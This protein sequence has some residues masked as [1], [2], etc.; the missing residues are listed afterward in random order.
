MVFSSHQ[1]KRNVSSHEKEGLVG[2]KVQGYKYI[3]LLV[4]VCVFFFGGWGGGVGWGI[5]K[6][7]HMN[8]KLH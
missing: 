2:L 7:N 8:S 3:E 1:P 6:F 5:S 4:C